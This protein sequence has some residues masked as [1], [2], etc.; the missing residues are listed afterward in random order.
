MK[1]QARIWHTWQ[2]FLA[3]AVSVPAVICAV[4]TRLTRM[5]KECTPAS[6][7]L[8]CVQVRG[9]AHVCL[10]LNALCMRGECFKFALLID[11]EMQSRGRKRRGTMKVEI[12]LLELCI[13]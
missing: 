11:N 13:I 5:G 3:C 8:K 10:R 4:A 2:C 6:H 12:R 9:C 7:A 1:S